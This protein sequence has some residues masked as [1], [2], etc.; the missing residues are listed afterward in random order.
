MIDGKIVVEG[1]G[2]MGAGIAQVSAARFWP[3]YLLKT[4]VG[5]ERLGRKAKR[6][7]FEYLP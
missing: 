2:A 4:Y 6:G 3:H 7:F 5:A 1:A